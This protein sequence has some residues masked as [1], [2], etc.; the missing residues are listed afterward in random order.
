MIKRRNQNASR[1]NRRYRKLYCDL[2]DELRALVTKILSSEAVPTIERLVGE[3]HY[4]RDKEDSS[5][6]SVKGEMSRL[7]KIFDELF[8]LL[9]GDLDSER[10]SDCISDYFIYHKFNFAEF[11]R[12]LST[13]TGHSGDMSLQTWIDSHMN[14]K[15]GRP[16]DKC[17]KHIVQQMI[18]IFKMHNKP[19]SHAKGARFMKLTCSLLSWIDQPH[20]IP[21]A[22]NYLAG[23]VKNVL[24][25]ERGVKPDYVYAP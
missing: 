25:R 5:P 15:A 22:N 11:R 7:K 4:I 13:A 17:V 24:E 1:R 23:T 19:I 20:V 6:K 18:C 10:T 2:P 21:D 8:V 14:V 16:E 3:C 9:D 12:L